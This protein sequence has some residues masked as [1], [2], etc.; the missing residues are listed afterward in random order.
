MVSIMAVSFDLAVE[1]TFPIGES[2]SSGVIMSGGQ[3]GGII[4]TLLTSKWLQDSKDSQDDDYKDTRG[5]D[6]SFLLLFI[7]C[8]LAFVFTM[9]IT[10][11]LKRIENENKNVGRPQLLE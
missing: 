1:L 9:F 5:S 10:Q 11:K 4:M 8:I 6:Y 2:F 3:I 7:A